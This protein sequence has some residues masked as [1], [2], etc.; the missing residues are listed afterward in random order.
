MKNKILK[1]T[2]LFLAFFSGVIATHLVLFSVSAH[3]G[4]A[5]FVHGCVRNLTGLLRIIG[6]NDT[7]NTNE[8]TL[9][10]SRNGI[11]DF[12]GFVTT[13]FNELDTYSEAWSYRN[14]DGA[15]FNLGSFN[16]TKFRGTSFKNAVFNG[17]QFFEVA[18]VDTNFSGST[19]NG[20]HFNGSDISNT[21][22]TNASFTG[23]NLSGVNFLNSLR[24]GV[25]WSNTICPDGTNSDANGNT[26]EGH[27]VP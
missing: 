26:C 19:F 22:F 7:C 1:Y 16:Q 21:N 17:T 13:Q 27:L 10:W 14:L 4:N 20:V 3:G 6:A 11:G 2:P 9:D 12:G 24:T 15:I 25:T 8:T 18:A 23:S 5:D